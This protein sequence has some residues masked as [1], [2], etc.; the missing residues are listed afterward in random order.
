MH[1]YQNWTAGTTCD[2]SEA[3]EYDKNGQNT[4]AWFEEKGEES[5]K[6]IMT[7]TSYYNN[8]LPKRVIADQG[9]SSHPTYGTKTGLQSITD[10]IYD[11]NGNLR[12]LVC[13]G[14]VASGST[15]AH[16]TSYVHT[17]M[18]MLKTESVRFDTYT[19][20]TQTLSTSGTSFST[21]YVYDRHGNTTSIKN[22][23]KDIT[24][25]YIYDY[26]DRN[27]A[28]VSPEAEMFYNG[29]SSDHCVVACQVYYSVGINKEERMV[30]IQSNVYVLDEAP[31]TAED[32]YALFNS[33]SNNNRL[34]YESDF[35]YNELYEQTLANVYQFEFDDLVNRK[36]LDYSTY[37][38]PSDYDST[39]E[40][41]RSRTESFKW[42]STTK[43]NTWCDML[44][45][46]IEYQS[47][48]EITGNP[49]Y[50]KNEYDNR[51][52]P[53]QSVA[54][55][56]ELNDT[57]EIKHYVQRRFDAY[58]RQIG[59]ADKG[60]TSTVIANTDTA[61]NTA[62]SSYVVTTQEFN[63]RGLVTEAVNPRDIATANAYDDLG[64]L[65]STAEDAA[66]GGIGATTCYAYYITTDK[67]RK[68][69]DAEGNDTF[70]IYDAAGRTT[71]AYYGVTAYNSSDLPST[72]LKHVKTVYDDSNNK[73]TVQYKDASDALKRE[74]VS[75][76]DALGNL[77]KEYLNTNNDSCQGYLSRT[78]EYDPAGNPVIARTHDNKDPEATGAKILTEVG[79]EYNSIGN[80]V[81]QKQK[82]DL[83]LDGDF[84]D[85]EEVK[86]V[87]YLF[88][89]YG[90]FRR[91][92]LSVRQCAETYNR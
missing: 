60:T 21:S 82:I 28:Q 4:K 48:I 53:I 35:R 44:G 73:V 45:R 14:Y 31:G 50:A 38:Y 52:F 55:D 32:I 88:R 75:E 36:T 24:V 26:L 20:S 25:N 86:E 80:L 37:V 7:E 79:S 30:P 15:T 9:Y 8:G 56:C 69:T 64:R 72:F 16:V 78:F 87:G 85:A 58:G 92:I 17:A 11:V 81:C 71:D 41:W 49:G 91:D 51:G 6:W 74:V 18:D 22:D 83:N 63:N 65:T 12:D 39:T 62:R 43:Q 13:Y 90:C 23:N 66:T 47:G 34:I 67:V 89:L 70:Y 57:T 29:T 2:Y 27:I 3:F 46:Q 5:S 68:I 59:V 1:V 19:P 77:K 54:F 33:S 10:Y 84:A 42:T 61:W 40:K 76:F